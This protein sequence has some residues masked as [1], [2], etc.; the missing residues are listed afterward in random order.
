[1]PFEII[2]F[3]DSQ[4]ILSKKRMLKN[5]QTTMEYLDDVLFEAPSR[6]DLLKQALEE[7]G[8]REN[9]S[10]TILD[11]RGYKFTGFKNRIAIQGNLSSYESILEGLFRLQV[12]F[13]KDRIDTGILLLTSQRGERTPFGSTRELCEWEVDQLHPTISMPVTVALF[14]LGES[15][16]N[17]SREN[18]HELKEFHKQQMEAEGLEANEG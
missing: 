6:G 5:I 18:L 15:I 17:S 1:M 12:S 7:M 13:D 14:D 2:H 9:G 8:W 3:R 16:K 10:L 4:K 11:G